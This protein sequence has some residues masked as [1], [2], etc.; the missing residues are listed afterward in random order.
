MLIHLDENLNSNL[1]PNIDDVF[2]GLNYGDGIF[3]TMIFNNDQIK[4]FSIHLERINTGLKTVEI[5]KLE[6]NEVKNINSIVLDN[7]INQVHKVK[8]YVIRENGGTFLPH[9]SRRKI[10]LEI[11]PFDGFQFKILTNV[12]YL[13]N[14]QNYYSPISGFKKLS[15]LNYVIAGL[16]IKNR[17]LHD[18]II[19]DINGNIS[20][21][22][23]SNIFWIKNNQLFTP[24]LETGCVNG[25]TRRKIISQFSVNEVLDRPETL[26]YAESVFTTN[27]ASMHLIEKLNHQVFDTKHSLLKTIKKFLF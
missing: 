3:E 16:E 17:K 4:D 8:L 10:I 27:V 24:S 13:K 23:V 1:K 2:R 22:L 15:S 5:D 11:L 25:I 19:T 20:E 12:N 21:C 6:P 9:S 7:C 18:G 26:D 14:T